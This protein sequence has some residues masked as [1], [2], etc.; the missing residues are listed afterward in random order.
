MT[1]DI[2]KC[3]DTPI[4]DESIEEYEYPEYE[5]ITGTNPN[6]GGDIRISMNCKTCSHILAKN[7]LIFKGRLTKADNTD[8]VNAD[9]VALTNNAKIDLSS[10]IEYHYYPIS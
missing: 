7:Y 6:N 5:S 4:I 2:L 9:E 3:T 8:Y 1:A 10:R